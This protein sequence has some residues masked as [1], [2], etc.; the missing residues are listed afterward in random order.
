MGWIF[1]V[2]FVIFL[3]ILAT[4]SVPE[5]TLKWSLPET[6]QDAEEGWGGHNHT[7]PGPGDD[8]LILPSE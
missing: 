2:T 8:V 1:I 3:Y 5:S 6:W 7:I 4:T